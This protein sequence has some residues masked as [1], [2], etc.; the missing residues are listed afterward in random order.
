MLQS[1]NSF[2]LKGLCPNQGLGFKYQ[3]EELL[4]FALSCCFVLNGSLTEF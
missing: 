4:C 2:A 3:L 1:T